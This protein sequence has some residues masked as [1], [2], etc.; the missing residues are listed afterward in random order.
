MLFTTPQV[1]KLTEAYFALA[2]AVKPTNPSVYLLYE[3]D[4]GLWFNWNGTAWIAYTAPV[5]PAA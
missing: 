1:V 2:A 5:T 4:T 3:V